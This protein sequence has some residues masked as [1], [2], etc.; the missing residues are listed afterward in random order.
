MDNL[1]KLIERK[2]QE[3]KLDTYKVN[4]ATSLTHLIYADDI[5]LLTKADRKSFDTIREILHTFH[6][7]LA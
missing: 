7:T 4:G 3:K 1:R 2:V 6:P 5:F